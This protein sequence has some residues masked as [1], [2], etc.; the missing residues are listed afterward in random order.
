MLLIN[1][2]KAGEKQDISEG[3]NTI[4]LSELPTGILIFVVGDKRFRF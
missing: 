4:N 1:E 3:E 2:W